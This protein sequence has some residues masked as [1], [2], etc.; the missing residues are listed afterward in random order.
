[1]SYTQPMA[2]RRNW[3]TWLLFFP[4]RLAWRITTALV[5][6]IGILL[7]LILGA[8]LMAVGILLCSTFIGAFV[9]APMTVIGFLI[10]LRALY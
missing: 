9:G 5:N 2:P 1:M 10:L 6:S 7:G 8:A 4:V 3:L